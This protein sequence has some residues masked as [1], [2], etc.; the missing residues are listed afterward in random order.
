MAYVFQ[1]HGH[2]ILFYGNFWQML[3]GDKLIPIELSCFF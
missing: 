3:L 1:L 2:A